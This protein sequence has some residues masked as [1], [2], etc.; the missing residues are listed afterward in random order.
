M[1]N[2][3]SPITHYTLNIG[4]LYDKIENRQK[5]AHLERSRGA[6]HSCI[7][8]TAFYRLPQCTRK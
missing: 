1:G 7:F 4:G 3:T 5:G 6:H 2:Y 8:D